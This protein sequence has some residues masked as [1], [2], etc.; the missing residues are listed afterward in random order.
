MKVY[1]SLVELIGKTPIM[2]INNLDVGKA[3]IFC[4][5]EGF[6]PAGSIKDRVAISLIEDA[7]EKGIIGPG[8]TI[9]EPTSGN[10]G[11]GLAAVAAA[12]GYKAIMVMPETMSVER[13]QLLAA[14][15]AEIVL[16]EAAKGMVG[17]IEKAKELN[18]QIPGSYIPG[19][20]ENPANPK[21]HIMTTGPELVA[22]MD[23]KIDILVAGVGTGGT[24]TGL[25]KYLKD[26][27]EGVKIVAVEPA[28][29]PMLSE[30]KAGPHGLQGIGANFVPEVLDR[31]VIDEIITVDDEDAYKMGR[32]F[33]RIEGMLIGVTSAAA[34][35]GAIE[36][37]NRPENQG[38]NIVVIIPDGGE[39]YLT[40]PMYVD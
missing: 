39:K 27:V 9:I 29:S 33:A 18:E 19:Q 36:I 5:L 31:D 15:G 17:S 8:A 40:T 34:I 25:G 32:A 26:H 35:H 30:G 24:I 13:R 1:N 21:A 7:E 37:G 23:G 28:R 20:F 38:K 16:T 6:N 3:N 11:I 22:D 12:R 4:K 10:T 2:K 14:Y